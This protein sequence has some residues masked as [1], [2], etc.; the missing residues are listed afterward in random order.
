MRDNRSANYYLHSYDVNR[1]VRM[2]RNIFQHAM[3][4]SKRAA[5]SS[6]NLPLDSRQCQAVYRGVDS[7]RQS[8]EFP[9]QLFV[10]A[11]QILLFSAA[12]LARVMQLRVLRSVHDIIIII[13]VIIIG[14]IVVV[15]TVLMQK[16]IN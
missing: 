16:M 6:L 7:L 15:V 3:R 1:V 11:R 2:K 9:D 8:L 12:D 13:I 14:I 5:I 4:K 10:L